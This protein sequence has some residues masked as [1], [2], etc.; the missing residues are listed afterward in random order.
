MTTM[1]NSVTI[2]SLAM[3]AASGATGSHAHT[4]QATA[5]IPSMATA[6]VVPMNRPV[7]ATRKPSRSKLSVSPAMKAMSAV[8]MPL[9]V[10]SSRA[11]GSVITL[12]RYGPTRIPNS[13]Y[14]VRRGSWNRRSSSPA[15]IAA[16]SVKPSASAVVDGSVPAVSVRRTHSTAMTTSA[17]PSRRF[18]P[19]PPGATPTAT[20]RLTQ[21]IRQ[22][23]P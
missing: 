4:I 16:I 15:T 18:M 11:I 8:A 23:R 17:T 20:A 9:T 3:P 12:P 10:W 7:P 5:N 1:T 22:P 19:A 13:R 6:M 21:A 14:P 2:A